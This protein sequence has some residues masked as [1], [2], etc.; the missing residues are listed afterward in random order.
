MT[1]FSAMVGRRSTQLVS[2]AAFHSLIRNG[3]RRDGRYGMQQFQLL[4]SEPS[5]RVLELRL[6][7]E[8]DMATVA[9]LRDTTR[10]AVA[11]GDYDCVVFDLSGV[12]FMDSTGLH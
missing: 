8:V 6:S 9:P 10:T 7:G 2:L 1:I 11:S 12:S 3:K 5:T 4:L